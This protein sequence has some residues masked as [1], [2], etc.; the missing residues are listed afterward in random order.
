MAISTFTPAVFGNA[1]T[2]ALRRS[3][4]RIAAGHSYRD[5]AGFW[6]RLL[7]AMVEARQRRAMIEIRRFEAMTGVRV[8][9]RADR[10][11]DQAYALAPFRGE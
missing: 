3:G 4:T 9:D 7:R 6:T 11:A 10:P 8:L 2:G 1:R 5:T